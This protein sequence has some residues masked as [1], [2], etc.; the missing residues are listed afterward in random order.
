MYRFDGPFKLLHADIGNLES[1]GKNA[2]NPQYALVIVDLCSSKVYVY[3]MRS[4]KQILQKIKLFYDE[5]RA[6]RKGKRMRL[7][8]D[9]EFQQ[10]KIKDL[11]DENNIDMFTSSVGGGKPFAA[12]QKIMELKTKISRLNVQKLKIRPTKIM[13]NSTLNMNLMKS[14]KYGLSPKEIERQSLTS[15]RFRILFNMQKIEKTQKLHARLDRYDKKRNSA[16]RKKLR[17]ELL[18]GKKVLVLAERIKN[19]AAPGKFYKQSVKTY[20]TSIKIGHL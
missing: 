3:S 9:N 6:K 19:K 2:T 11:N 14:V 16:N 4:R 1:L 18:I 7:P 10:V 12:E 17:E 8:V 5:V 20:L 15:E 13:Q